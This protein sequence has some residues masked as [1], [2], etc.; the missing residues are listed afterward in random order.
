MLSSGASKNQ[1]ILVVPMVFDK[2]K[3]SRKPHA[4]LV[5]ALSFGVAA[6]RELKLP[7]SCSSNALN[8]SSR[9]LNFKGRAPAVITLSWFPLVPVVD[10]GIVRQ[11]MTASFRVTTRQ[12]S[13]H[14]VYFKVLAVS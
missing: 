12:L 10:I 2:R 11:V 3:M 5:P 14:P 13:C 7:V 8:L 4:V 6:S 9:R 1:T